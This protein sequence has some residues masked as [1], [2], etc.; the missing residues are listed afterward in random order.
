MAYEQILYAVEDGVATITLNRPERLNAWNGA[1]AT[2]VKAAMHAASDDAAVKV[3]VLTGAG[4]GFCSGADMN[5]LQGIQAGG[6]STGAKAIPTSRRSRSRSSR[7][8]TAPRPA[9]A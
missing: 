3:I 9:L 5:T 1:I 4:R 2:E 7:R 8:S 6:A